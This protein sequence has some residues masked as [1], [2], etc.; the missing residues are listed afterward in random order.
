MTAFQQDTTDFQAQSFDAVN[1][2]VLTNAGSLRVRGLEFDLGARFTDELSLDVTGAINDAGFRSFPNAQCFSR[3]TE[4]TGCVNGVQDLSGRKANNVSDFEI[5]I[6]P[7]YNGDIN[8][9]LSFFAGADIAY[10][11]GFNSFVSLDPAG[12]IEGY[13]IVNLRAGI[14]SRALGLTVSGFVRNALDEEFLITVFENPFLSG[15]FHGY[16]GDP[17]TFGVILQKT[18]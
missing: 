5:T 7:A 18:F 4:A 10:R 6:S 8:D 12:E 11:S 1:G 3:Q 15:T 9:D 13:T 17:R 16:V 14:E 2:F